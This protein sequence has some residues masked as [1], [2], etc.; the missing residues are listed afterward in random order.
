MQQGSWGLDIPVVELGDG[1][2]YTSAMLLWEKT[3][4]RDAG[5]WTSFAWLLGVSV[6]RQRV[7]GGGAR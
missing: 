7:G 4:G 6:A 1:G 5:R 2:D 3:A